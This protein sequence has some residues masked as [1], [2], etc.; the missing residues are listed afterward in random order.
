VLTAL[1]GDND[2]SLVQSIALLYG[3]TYAADGDWL[4]LTAPAGD[5]VH[6][7]GFTNPLITVFDITNPLRVEQVRGNISSAGGAYNV[8]FNAPGIAGHTRT[9]VAF[10]ADQ[11]EGP[12]AMTHHSPTEWGRRESSA[13]A[14]IISHPDF[15]A[16]LAPLVS[17]RRAQGHTVALVP[18]DELYDE[19]N[20][21]ERSPFA[22]R[23]FLSAAATHWR[24]PPQ[25]VLLVGDASFDPR[26]YLGL[27]EF[28][29]VP[30]RIIETSAMKTAS[31]DWFT[32]FQGNGY[33]TL[34]TGRLPV[35]T[36]A[37]AA[38]VAGKIVGYETG[39]SD[40]P[41]TSQVLLIGDQNGGY[42]FTGATNAVGQLLPSS[43]GVTK[44]LADGQDPTLVQQQIV[45]AMNS[46]QVLVNYLGHGS[47]EQWS[48]SSF[49][50]DSDATALTNGGNL[51]LVVSMDCLSGFFHD[52]YTTS[53][54]ES[55]LLAPK[56]GAV[57]VWASSGFT[58]ADPQA[59]MDRALV[60][61]I[62]A[63]PGMPIG[64][65]ILK[66]KA[67]TVDPDVR[68]TWILFGDPA[69]RLRLPPP[70]Q[71]AARR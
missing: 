64:S 59:T 38:T 7:T 19:F 43:L 37:D 9:L 11:I 51:P 67:G 46:G 12:A 49:F 40:G 48:L 18:V 41:W 10:S 24:R 4:R 45:A 52:V 66:A 30:T 32:D 29:F 27:G 70:A 14:V 22:L 25:T 68:R 31:D 33:A 15:T 1:E 16:S 69:M 42:D 28:D 8:D 17:L 54:A 60:F 65:A 6:V 13:G 55:L 56:G 26:N 34:A 20:F 62:F 71:T 2:V 39:A 3:H 58:G 57:A 61:Q 5:E 35:R 44:I 50:S 47:V 23:S 63:N 53:L 36:A 21:G